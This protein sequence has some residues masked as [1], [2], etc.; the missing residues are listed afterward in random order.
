MHTALQ[1]IGFHFF[2]GTWTEEKQQKK[3]AQAEEQE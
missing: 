3:V 1:A 2:W